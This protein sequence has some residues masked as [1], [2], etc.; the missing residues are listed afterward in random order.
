MSR[1]QELHNSEYV[2]TWGGGFEEGEGRAGR[3]R[4]GGGEFTGGGGKAGEAGGCVI[5][6]LVE[7]Y[8]KIV[9]QC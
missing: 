1:Q 7:Q 3:W 5:A 2:D 6:V 8:N 9:V 4:G